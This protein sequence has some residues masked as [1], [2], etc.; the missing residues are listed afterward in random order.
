MVKKVEGSSQPVHR[1]I[2]MAREVNLKQEL[3]IGFLLLLLRGKEMKVGL[4]NRLIGKL[5]L[6]FTV[7]LFIGG[8]EPLRRTKT[9]I[10]IV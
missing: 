1:K 8:K 5:G 2:E 6:S 10:G 3:F 4:G 7:A 9:R